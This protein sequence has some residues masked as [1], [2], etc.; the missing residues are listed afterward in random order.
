MTEPVSA[1]PRPRW[2]TGVGAGVSVVGLGAS[3]SSPGDLSGILV[4]VGAA[5]L[6]VGIGSRN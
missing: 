5:L 1:R 2:I 3:V 4:L 6:A